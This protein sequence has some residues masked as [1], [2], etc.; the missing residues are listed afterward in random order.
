MKSMIRVRQKAVTKLEVLEAISD[1]VSLDLLNI[2][3]NKSET[4]NNL[5]EQLK[6][7]RRKYFARLSKLVDTGL[8][9]RKGK[10][11]A[12]TS[13]GQLIYN[14]QLK[15]TKAAE[16]LPNLKMIDAL[17]DSDISRDDY[18]EFIDK[19]INDM[20]IKNIILTH[21]RNKL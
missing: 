11:Y 19:F 4:S 3:F 14:A 12:I 6:L 1:D 20:E 8:V 7:S 16:N 13:F 5:K 9:K 2:I 21:E 10:N 17:K 15:V 18:A